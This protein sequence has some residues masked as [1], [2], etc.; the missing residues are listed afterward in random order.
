MVWGASWLLPASYQSEAVILVEQQ[1]VPD[2]YVTP[3]ITTT[4]QA[5]VQGITQQTLSR[6]RL[7]ETINH[8]H[9][10]SSQHGLGGL[11]KS[12][13]PIDQMRSDIKIE[14]VDTP[15][16][17]GEFAAFKILYSAR[18][19]KVAQQVNGELTSIFVDENVK[20]QR[21]LSENTT[22]FL[23]NQLADARAKMEEQEAKVAAFKAKHVGDL[24]G[25]MESNVQILAGLQAQLQNTQ[26]ALDNAKQQKIYLQS[27]L[28]EYQSAQSSLVNGD[29][30]P[31]S[32]E[33]LDKQLMDLRLHL[34][35]LHS[36]YTDDHPDIIA[37]KGTI[38]K[39]IKLKKQIEDEMASDH[40]ADKVTGSADLA[41]MEGLQRGSSTA[42]MQVQSQYKANQVEIQNYQQH[43]KELEL[44]ISSYQGR[45]NMTPEIEQELTDISRGYEESK[46]NYN[47][48]LQKQM[49]SQLATSLEQH[50][51]GEQFRIIDPPSLPDKPAA[52]N[53][54]WI[55]LGGLILGSAVGLLLAG[56][57]E[58]TDVRVW[59]E[60]DLEELVPARVLV[61]IPRLSTPKEDNSRLMVRWLEIGAAVAIS[62]LITVGNLYAFYKG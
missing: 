59:Q 50:Q 3:N 17:P 56:F 35:D 6:T 10:Y 54:F 9:L 61:G 33:A 53:H 14:L 49:Q 23:E 13:D 44:Q 31:M 34:E 11:L 46:T 29:S 27:L 16:H 26:Q 1:K 24:P 4:L 58:L 57:L 60:K 45:L 37:L 55:S 52:P 25:Q 43:E 62:V 38:A 22:A 30:T 48:L 40:G 36:H 20:A 7:Q 39:T 12:G 2:Q 51:Q 19:P 41:S 32:T 15:G 28:Q 8:F 21:Q 18:S 47:S 42:M 5:R